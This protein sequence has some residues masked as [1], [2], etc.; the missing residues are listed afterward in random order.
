MSFLRYSLWAKAG[1]RAHEPLVIS[2]ITTLTRR[3]RTVPEVGKSIP[4]RVRQPLDSVKELSLAECAIA[5][6]CFYYTTSVVVLLGAL[7]GWTSVPMCN[8]HA[9]ARNDGVLGPFVAWDGRWY[10]RIASV[11]Y[12]YHSNRESSVAFFPAYPAVAAVLARLTGMRIRAA[13]LVVSH[14]S[15]AGALGLLARY[16]G[17]RFPGE[18]L[19]RVLLAIG[20]FPT[21]FYLR[22]GYSESLMLL[23]LIAAM[24]GMEQRWRPIWIALAVG[25]ATATRPVGVAL[26]LPF[27]MHIWASVSAQVS[28]SEPATRHIAWRLAL[29]AMRAIAL[30]PL[31]CWGIL[32]YM[33]YQWWKFDEPLAFVKTQAHWGRSIARVPVWEHVWGLLTLAPVRKVYDSVSPCYWGNFPPRDNPLFNLMFANP[34]YFI[35]AVGCVGF[36]GWKRWLNRKELALSAMLLLIPYVTQADRMCMASQARFA[37]VVFPMYLVL[38]QILARLPAPVVALLAAV[39]AVMLALYSALFVNWYWYY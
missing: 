31:A 9:A 11:G 30:S 2:S 33:G 36:G 37:S 13:L 32:V 28:T 1:V 26:L 25:A 17:A 8:E 20:L 14:L 5:A 29:F 24:L 27:A 7:F 16:A 15:F 38:G 22:M 4:I 18:R 6:I 21:T 39:S 23:V 3:F 19:D 10:E 35:M 12:N 34:V